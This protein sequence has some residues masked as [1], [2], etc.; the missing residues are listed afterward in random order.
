MKNA[1]LSW[2]WAV[3]ILTATVLS[4]CNTL[5]GAGKDVERAGEGIQNATCTEQEKKTDPNC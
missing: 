3:T 2:C 4:G 1:M 5:E